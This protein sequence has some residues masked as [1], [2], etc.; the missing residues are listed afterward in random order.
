VSL[1][2]GWNVFIQLDVNISPHACFSATWDKSI[3]QTGR[4]LPN[5]RQ[6]ASMCFFFFFFFFFFFLFV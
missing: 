4:E 1:L 6:S 2:V 3:H 5:K